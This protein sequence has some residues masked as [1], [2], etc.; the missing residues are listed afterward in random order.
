MVS[1]RG[2]WRERRVAPAGDEIDR[3]VAGRSV[4]LSWTLVAVVLVLVVWRLL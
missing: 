2:D 1:G 3:S 4:L